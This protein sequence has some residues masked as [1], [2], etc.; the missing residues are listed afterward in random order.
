MQES[1]SISRAEPRPLTFGRGQAV[2][3]RR[4]AVTG[5]LCALCVL[6][7][8]A[9]SWAAVSAPMC[10]ELAQSVEAPPTLWPFRGGS[11]QAAPR[12]PDLSVAHHE[13]GTPVRANGAMGLLA[14]EAPLSVGSVSMRAPLQQ[15]LRIPTCGE[16]HT[17]PGHYPDVYRPPRA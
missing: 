6:L 5:V 2:C 7:L 4:A 17:R 10:N 3:H 12:C 8:P 9:V 11:V 13:D 16:D 15:R 1:A 14:R